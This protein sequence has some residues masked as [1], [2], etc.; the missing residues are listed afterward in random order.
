MHNSKNTIMQF[1]NYN[2]F[3]YNSRVNIILLDEKMGMKYKLNPTKQEMEHGIILYNYIQH[4]DLWSYVTIDGVT[5]T[6]GMGRWPFG[7]QFQE[8]EV[9]DDDSDDNDDDDYDDNYK[10]ED[11]GF[12]SDDYNEDEWKSGMGRWPFGERFQE[13]EVMGDDSDD[14]DDDDNDDYDDDYKSE[15][16]G[17]CS[18]DY[19]EDEWD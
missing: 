5:Y 13:E 17:F 11:E 6:N 16:E 4:G 12:C 9:M 3:F 18:D 8:E 10:S 1:S 7:E 14:N 19:N 2:I 15:D